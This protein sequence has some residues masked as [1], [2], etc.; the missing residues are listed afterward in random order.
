MG[1]YFPEMKKKHQ[2]MLKDGVATWMPSYIAETYNL[3]NVIAIL[4][5]V[6]IPIFNIIAV[7]LA[8]RLHIK[9]F[10]N[11]LICAGVFYLGSTISSF[12]MYVI[13]GNIATFSVILGA[14]ITGCMHG[15]NLMLVC[16]IPAY[17]KKRDNVSTVSGIINCASYIG[18]AISTYGVALLSEKMGWSFTLLSWVLTS[19]AGGILC[20][21]ISK[22]WVRFSK[23]I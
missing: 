9:V 2:G 23:N 14:T 11:P 18:T 1:T 19:L 22:V 6:A 8:T 20:F 7:T 5:G 13:S 21:S 12:I 16:M 15:I 10:K 3:T 4:T 17:F